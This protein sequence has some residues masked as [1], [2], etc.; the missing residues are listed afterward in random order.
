MILRPRAMEEI[1]LQ[2]PVGLVTEDRSAAGQLGT[3]DARVSI[4]LDQ[5]R[6]DV[7]I[8]GEIPSDTF[9]VSHPRMDAFGYIL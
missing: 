9:E 8:H 3:V 7:I 2:Y 5:Y 4:A 1:V 6:I